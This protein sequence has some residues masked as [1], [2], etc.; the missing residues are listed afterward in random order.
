[1][2]TDVENN[3]YTVCPHCKSITK[4]MDVALHWLHCKEKDK[5]YSIRRMPFNNLRDKLNDD[6]N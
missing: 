1:M 3:P 2:K 6:T 4:L 5:A